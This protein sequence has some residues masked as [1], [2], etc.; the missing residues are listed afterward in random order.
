MKTVIASKTRYLVSLSSEELTAL[1]NC[2]NE[3]LD[4]STLDEHDCAT[5]LGIDYEELK[6]LH[7]ALVAAVD[8]EN[9]SVTEVF[10]AWRDG[11]SVQ[12]RAISAFGDPADLSFEEVRSKI[13]PILDEEEKAQ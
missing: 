8:S 11:A 13:Q 5:R 7:R 10:E 4:N 2:V 9:G 12:I 1:A 3:V 6:G